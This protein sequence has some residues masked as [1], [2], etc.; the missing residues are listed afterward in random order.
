LIYGERLR[1]RNTNELHRG[2]VLRE[3]KH[4]HTHTHTYTHEKRTKEKRTKKKRKREREEDKGEH[5]SSHTVV[6]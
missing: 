6:I 2:K 3:V 5:Q 1:R 4:T